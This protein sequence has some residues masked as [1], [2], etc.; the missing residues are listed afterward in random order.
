MSFEDG[1][2]PLQPHHVKGIGPS[3]GGL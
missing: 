2:K 1:F 3:A